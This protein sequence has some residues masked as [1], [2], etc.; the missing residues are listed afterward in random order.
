MVWFCATR[1]G[2]GALEPG[3]QEHGCQPC[4]LAKINRRGSQ[5]EVPGYLNVVHTLRDLDLSAPNSWARYA[6]DWVL[7]GEPLWS[8]L[9]EQVRD[10]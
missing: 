8:E 1:C 4:V 3:G 7:P 5:E 6:E 10:E 9:W 2:G